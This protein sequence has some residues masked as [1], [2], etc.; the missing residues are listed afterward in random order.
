[1]K[2]AGCC[3]G[4]WCTKVLEAAESELGFGE[5]DLGLLGRLGGRGWGLR[6]RECRAGLGL[7]SGEG[8]GDFRAQAF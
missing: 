8:R 3:F 4:G 1:M 2:R 7:I 6:I 5:G